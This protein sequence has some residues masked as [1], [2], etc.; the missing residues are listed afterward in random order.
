M[1]L[2]RVIWRAVLT[3]L[4][5]QAAMRAELQLIREQQD[6]II[7]LLTIHPADHFEFTVQVEGETPIIGATQM[8]PMTDSQRAQ[9]SI[10][11]LDRKKKPAPLDGVPAW[12]SSDETVVTVQLGKLEPD[13]SISPDDTGLF[14]VAEGVAPNAVDASGQPIPARITV[15]GDANMD[16]DTTSPITGILE[17][18][19]TAGQA[20]TVN[21][22]MGTPV[23]IP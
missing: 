17:V 7:D 9:L 5:N 18:I 10:R 3:V 4:Q 6:Q 20:I 23:E 12:A 1:N 14:A 22:D 2:L 21:I 8:P 16:P 13:G 19:V 11:P 15:S